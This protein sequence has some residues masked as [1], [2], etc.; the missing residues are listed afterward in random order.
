MRRV[1]SWRPLTCRQLVEFV[2]D[3]LEA[4]L[5]PRDGARFERHLARCPGCRAYL[6]QM[7]R[8]IRLVG[9]LASE[10]QLA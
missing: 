8:T 2:T 4:A 1:I 3:Y 9:R 5:S 10:W 7:R 6:D